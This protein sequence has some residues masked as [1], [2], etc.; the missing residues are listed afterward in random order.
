MEDKNAAPVKEIKVSSDAVCPSCGKFVGPYEKCPY[1]QADLHKRLS[2]KLVKRLSVI[3]SIVGL[4]MLWYASKMHEIPV[5]KISSITE[6]M[7]NAL[8]EVDGS[9]VAA[10]FDET[11]NNFSYTVAD[12]TGKM[13][14]NGFNALNNFKD[15]FGD[16][17]PQEGDKI[18]AVGQLNISEKFG[19][20]MFIK[21]PKRIAV[22]EKYIVTEKKIKDITA[23][24][25]KKS[26][27]F[28][29]TIEDVERE[30]S[31]GKSVSVSDGSDSI[32]LTVFNS[33]FEKITDTA[34]KEN[35]LVPGAEYLMV[36]TV[37]SYRGALQLKLKNPENPKNLKCIKTGSVGSG[38]QFSE[39]KTPAKKR[40]PKKRIEYKE[41]DAITIEG[42]DSS[43]KSTSDD[44]SKDDD[45]GFI[46]KEEK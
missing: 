44:K 31:V 43:G 21:N 42:E 45:N 29:V 46:I 35:L 32:S 37:D 30:F 14:L 28:N 4:M 5:V 38:L 18:R 26:F 6:R 36:A 17:L 23:N 27:L 9:I 34:T 13:K 3:G 12:G 16:N 8:V 41:E 39:D 25:A 2:L 22:T 24:D 7:N 19:V 11:K 10:R 20:S 1:C 40:T 33:D 15:V